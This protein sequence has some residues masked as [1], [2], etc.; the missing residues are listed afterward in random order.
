MLVIVVREVP[1]TNLLGI[2]WVFGRC[3]PSLSIKSSPCLYVK[4]FELNNTQPRVNVPLRQCL[5]MSVLYGDSHCLPAALFRSDLVSRVV[6][7]ITGEC[8]QKV[9]QSSTSDILLVFAQGVDISGIKV[10]LESQSH[11][12]GKPVHLKCVRSRNTAF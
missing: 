7:G 8:L 11:W 6:F 2:Y 12:M 1:T 10:Q 4:M 9:F 5:V 3:F